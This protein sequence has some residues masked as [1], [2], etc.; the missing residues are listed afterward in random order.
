[1]NDR[2]RIIFV[3]YFFPPIGGAA[4]QRPIQLL[5]HLS[6]HGYEPVVITGPGNTGGRWTPGDAS[7]ARTI[8]DD[9]D[10]RRVPGPEPSEIS[11]WRSRAERWLGRRS[12]WAR[13]WIEGVVDEAA[14]V[15][16]D[17]ALVYTVISPY[18]TSEACTRIASARDVPWVPDLGDP[19]ALDDMAMYPTALHRRL[20]VR[21]M[22]RGLETAARIV[23]STPEAERRVRDTLG[24]RPERMWIVPNGF[25]EADFRG[26]APR[27]EPDGVIRVVHTGYLHAEL[28]RGQK[29]SARAHGLLGGGSPGVEILTRSHIFLLEAVNNLLEKRP[30]VGRRIEVHL[31]GVTT[32]T[33]EEIAQTCPAVRLHGYLPHAESVRLLETADLLFLPMQKL[34]RGLRSGNVPGKTYEYLASRRPILAAVPEGDARDLLERAGATYVCEPDD[35]AAM[36]EIL[37]ARVRSLDG[38]EPPPARNREVVAEYEWGNLAARVASA[39][40]SIL[41]RRAS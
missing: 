40:D 29:A 11:R 26:D 21:K 30:A 22:R 25:D 38:G 16:G 9:L 7:L 6:R 14:A 8:P 5:R 31:A 19:W 17:V 23:M 2:R 36:E 3:S 37:A 15:E 32:Q 27:R 33:D 1:M 41:G 4:A 28:G 20:E 12:E 13:W 39:L 34:A 10:V 35:V 18:E 24:V